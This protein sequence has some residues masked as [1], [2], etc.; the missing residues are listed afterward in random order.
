MNISDWARE[1][2]SAVIVKIVIEYLSIVL[3]NSVA[4]SF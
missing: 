2:L 1:N 4:Q 3:L